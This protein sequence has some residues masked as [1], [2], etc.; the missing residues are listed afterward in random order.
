M[1]EKLAKTPKGQGRLKKDDPLNPNSSSAKKK[2]KK[3][4]EEQGLPPL[5]VYRGPPDDALDVPGGWPE[6]WMKLKYERRSGS[7]AGTFDQYWLSPGGRKLRS[8]VREKKTC[9]MVLF[10]Y[11]LYVVFSQST[12]YL[13]GCFTL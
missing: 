9:W 5:E 11:F 12:L 10:L 1:Q 7:S 6:G 4:G 3:E 13:F 8:K 2:V